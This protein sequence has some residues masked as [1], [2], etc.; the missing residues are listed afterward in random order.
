MNILF[1][2]YGDFES[3]ISAV[4]S[5]TRMGPQSIK[6]VE[7]ADGYFIV[8]DSEDFSQDEA[9]TTVDEYIEDYDL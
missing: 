9:E 1:L 6:M 7:R 8:T 3:L 5:L 4:E 2:D